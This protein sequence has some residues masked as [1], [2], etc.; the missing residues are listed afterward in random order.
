MKKYLIALLAL[1]MMFALAVPALAEVSTEGN[2]N[3]D[4]T[5]DYVAPE[6]IDGGEVYRVT[7]TW[8]PK[9]GDPALT[10][11][12]EKTTYTWNTESLNYEAAT[13]AEAGWTGSTGY[14]VTVT[15]YSNATVE[16]SV[17]ATANYGLSVE[18]GHANDAVT[19][20]SAAVTSSGEA[21]KFTETDKTGT[22][23]PETFTFTYSDGGDAEAPT[24]AADGKVTI[25]K[26][27]VTLGE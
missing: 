25:G 17:V 19:L 6:D 2:A 22:A 27:T 12:D 1:V 16:A 15:N 8:E 23:Q 11:T 13:T 9:V 24:D 18:K 26:I 5:A 20:K 3:Q 7:I 21:I 10:F 14:T 4:V